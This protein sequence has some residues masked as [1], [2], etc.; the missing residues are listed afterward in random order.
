[1]AV[2]TWEVGTKAATGVHRTKRL[3]RKLKEYYKVKF[4][5]RVILLEE[6]EAP[7]ISRQSAHEVTGLSALST[8]HLYPQEIIPDIHFCQG[9]GQ[10]QGHNAIGIIKSTKNLND[11]SGIE[12]ATFRVVA[13][14]LNQLPHRVPLKKPY[15]DFQL[16][17]I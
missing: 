10:I 4:I 16:Y 9:L 5:Y 11:R 3:L 13:Q 14:F 17:L 6:F 15:N 8:D 7:R 1:V 12:I 2:L